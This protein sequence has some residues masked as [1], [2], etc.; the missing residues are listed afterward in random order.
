MITQILSSMVKNFVGTAQTFF[1]EQAAVSFRV[2]WR[3]FLCSFYQ[4]RNFMF[5]WLCIL[6]KY[7]PISSSNFATQKAQKLIIWNV[8]IW[9]PLPFLS[10][11]RQKLSSWV[12]L[13]ACDLYVVAYRIH[14]H[15]FFCSKKEP[16]RSQITSK[17]YFQWKLC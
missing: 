6:L 16:L 1:R 12:V 15:Y 2:A 17:F 5:T 9:R 8:Q 13:V 11:G 7:D 3:H 10:P 4:V 14:F